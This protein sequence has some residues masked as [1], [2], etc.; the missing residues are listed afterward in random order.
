[1]AGEPLDEFALERIGVD[2]YQALTAS[3]AGS[4]P[5]L[6]GVMVR[7]QERTSAKGNRFAFLQLSGPDGMFEV[8]LFSEALSAARELLES[9]RPLLVS[10]EAR[11]AFEK[12]RDAEDVLGTQMKAVGE[13]MSI[14]KTY[15]EA[16]QKAIRSLENGRPG[17]GFAK[18]FNERSL[19]DHSQ[20]R[21]LGSAPVADD[22]LDVRFLR[23]HP[24]ARD[25][26]PPAEK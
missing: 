4:R 10:C 15:K 25:R 19:D 7:K 24:T 17:L 22:A 11:W 23:E 16:F 2:P 14:G 8:V 1:M 20:W 5:K 13:A 12:F 3:A 26:G 18:D 6:A 9:G 21:I